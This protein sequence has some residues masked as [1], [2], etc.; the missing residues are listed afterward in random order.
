MTWIAPD[1]FNLGMITGSYGGMGFNPI[2]TLDWN[3]SGK[4]PSLLAQADPPLTKHRQRSIV[5]A[6][7]VDG[8]S[9][10]RPNPVRSH[11]HC[12]VLR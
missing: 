3:T 11:H 10:P 12:N 7:L 5:D 9:I 8:A 4:S 6:V 1:N 2:S